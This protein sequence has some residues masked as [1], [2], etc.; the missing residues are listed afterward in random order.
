MFVVGALACCAVVLAAGTA[1]AGPAAE[2]QA[3]REFKA[4]KKALLELE[5][6]VDDIISELDA[7]EDEA[8]ELEGEIEDLERDIGRVS[9]RAPV[10]QVVALV[11]ALGPPVQEPPGELP[12][13]VGAVDADGFMDLLGALLE[14]RSA[15]EESR[16]RLEEAEEELAEADDR[17]AELRGDIWSFASEREERI[18]ALDVAISRLQQ[19]RMEA[20]PTSDAIQTGPRLITYSADWEATAMCESSGRWHIDA[21]FDGGLQFLPSTWL[22]F[23]GG[24]Y[25]R[26]AYQATKRQQIEIAERVLAVQGPNAWPNCFTALPADT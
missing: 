13:S 7:A 23:G 6:E 8:R 17:I 1:R 22:G 24:E 19:S 10:Y 21:Y 12:E 4:A 2:K 20:P 18:D 14:D 3:R 9:S 11:F 15:L 5:R 16:E 26:F 25:G